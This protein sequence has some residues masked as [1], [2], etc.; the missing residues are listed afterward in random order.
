MSLPLSGFLIVEASSDDGPLALRLATSLAGRVCADLGAEVIKLEPQDGD[1][2]RRIP[3][4]VGGVGA[5]FVFLNAGKK[6]VTVAPREHDSVL[7]NLFRR[8]DAAIVDDRLAGQV[9]A[10]L[11]PVATVVSMFGDGIPADWSDTWSFRTP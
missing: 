2:V 4:L 9:G 7:T 10:G 3:P 1:P 11:P 6:S 8:A 5:T